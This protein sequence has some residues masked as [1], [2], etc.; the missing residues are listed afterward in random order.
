MQ[1]D[2]ESVSMFNQAQRDGKVE[3]EVEKKK[4]MEMGIWFG[5]EEFVNGEEEDSGWID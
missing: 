3:S 4:E 1:R 2:E 5:V